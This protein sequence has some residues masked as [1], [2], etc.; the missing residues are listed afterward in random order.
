[1]NLTAS[2]SHD[3]WVISKSSLKVVEFDLYAPN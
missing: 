2:H 1:M 3:I